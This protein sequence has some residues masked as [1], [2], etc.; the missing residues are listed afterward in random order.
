ASARFWI[1][2]LHNLT[3]P[4]IGSQPVSL[5][6]SHAYF[7]S[8]ASSA[9]ARYLSLRPESASSSGISPRLMFSG[10]TSLKSS[11]DICPPFLKVASDI[12]LRPPHPLFPL[13][14]QINAGYIP[15]LSDLTLSVLNEFACCLVDMHNL[16]AFGLRPGVHAFIDREVKYFGEAEQA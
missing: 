9:K 4:S 5:H 12:R 14:A 16:R 7:L 13:F 11:C 10:S 1:S 15:A 3:L 8:A 6:F 2:H